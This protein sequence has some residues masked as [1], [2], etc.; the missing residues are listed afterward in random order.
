MIR[1][2]S[3]LLCV[4]LTA[5]CV[6]ADAIDDY[7]SPEIAAKHIPGLSLAVVRDGKVEKLS[8][9]GLANVELAV[10][11][12]PQTVFQIQSITKTFTSAA[13]FMLMEEGK[14]SLD[15]PIGTHLE[16]TPDTW[17]AITLRHLLSHT[18]GIKD[19]INE[20][21]ASLRLDVSE[22]DVLR[23]TAPRPLNFQ[24]GEK[25]AYSNTNYHLLAMV[26]RKITGKSF[27]D[28]L[29]ERIFTPLGMTNTRIVSLSEIIPNRAAGYYWENGKLHN[30]TYIAQSILSYGGGGIVS[31]AEDMA[32]WAIALDGDKL[33]KWASL[34]AAWTPMKLNDGS[35]SVYGLGWGVGTVNGHRT[36]GHSGA[37]ATGF[38]SAIIR[39]RDD[40]LS[41]I[42]LTNSR[43]ADPS[44]IAKHIA[45]MCNPALK[46]APPAKATEKK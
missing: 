44:A 19:F 3:A 28:Y 15:D 42:V 40:N 43:S 16:G 35:N 32:K 20:P 27:G 22:A 30:G 1:M 6:R 8:A 9:Y 39:F 25:Y 4:V 38:T 18:S 17:K 21:T 2:I 45:G 34:Q 14:L 41:I 36:V 12:S 33:L 29:G 37:H 10:P 46:P 5:S 31:T 7:L 13:I 26:I 11:A 23:A 24:P